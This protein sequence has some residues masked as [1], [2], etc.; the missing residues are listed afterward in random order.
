MALLGVNAVSASDAGVYFLQHMSNISKDL[1]QAETIIFVAGIDKIVENERAAMLH[2]EAMGQFGLESMLLDIAPH[3][4]EKYDFDALPT[5][6]CE[7]TPSIHFILFDNGRSNLLKG[8]TMISFSA[9]TA[10]PVP[11]SAL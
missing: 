4:I 5:G 3:D 1:E 6:L 11:A 7:K 8:I 10:G 9:L 2:C